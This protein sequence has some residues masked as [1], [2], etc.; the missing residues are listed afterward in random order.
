MNHDKQLI[1][2]ALDHIVLAM[3][4]ILEQVER[5]RE[6]APDGSERAAYLVVLVE[7]AIMYWLAETP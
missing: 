2:A 3:T 5:K 1:G 7:R 4:E 6:V